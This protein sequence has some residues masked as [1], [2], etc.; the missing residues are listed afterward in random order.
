MSEILKVAKKPGSTKYNKTVKSRLALKPKL[1]RM[2][3]M[4]F[5]NYCYSSVEESTWYKLR[6]H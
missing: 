6:Q 4:T 3:C 1:F 2:S 5:M